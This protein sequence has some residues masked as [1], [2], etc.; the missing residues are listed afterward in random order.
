MNTYYFLILFLRYMNLLKNIAKLF[1]VFV[2]PLF[3]LSSNNLWPQY[4]GKN[5]TQYKVFDWKYIESQHFDVYYDKGS[6]Y[7]AEFAA[8]TLEESLLSIQNTLNYRIT[9]RIAVII[10][11]S[12]NDFQQTN[13]IDVYLSQGIGGVTELYKNRVIVP[14]QGEY[15]QFNHVLHH[16][17]VHAVLN[18]MFYGGNIQTAITTTNFSIPLWMNEGLAEW[19]SLGGMNIETDM[20]M[21][22]LSMNDQIPELETISG[23]AAYRCGQTFYAY[24]ASKYGKNKVTELINKLKIFRNLDMAFENSFGMNIKDFS[25]NWIKDIKKEYWPDI[26]VYQ[27]PK[28]FSKALTD[29]KK[30]NCFYFSSPA[31]SPDGEYMA[32]ISDMS[33]GIFSIYVAPVENRGRGKDTIKPKKI[34]SSAR[35][36]DFEQ[37]NV[38]TPGISWSPD[39][40]F[41][42]VSAKSGGEDAIFIVNVQTKKYEKIKPGFSSI[43]SV[44]WSPDGK[45]IAF[46]GI[47]DLRSDLFYY[48]LDDKTV[49]KITDDVFSDKYPAWSYDSENIFFVSDRGDN[50]E[51]YVTPEKLKIWKVNNEVSDIY[52]VNIYSHEITRITNEPNV[53][54]TS[55]AVSNDNKK[56]LYVSTKNGIGNIYEYIIESNAERPLTNCANGIA[57]LSLTPDNLTLI[58]SVQINGGYD[59]FLLRNPFE[60]QIELTELPKTKFLK[61]CENTYNLVNDVNDIDETEDELQEISYGDFSVDFSNQQFVQP[62][63]TMALQNFEQDPNQD[64]K[65]QDVYYVEK[66][67][68][69][70]FSLDV[71][72]V[73][74]GVSTFYG[75]QGNGAV[76]F[77]DIM[78]NHQIYLQMYLLSDLKNSQFYAAYLYNAKII[79]Y[80]IS[81]YNSSAYVWNYLDELRNNYLYSYR[82]TGVSLG[83]RYPF[84]LFRRLEGTLNFVNA[85]KENTE[86]PSYESVSRFLVVPE[87]QFVLD[88]S[89][90]GIYAPTRGTRLNARA[91]FSPKL[92]ENASDFITLTLDARQYI[93]L[94]PNFMCFALRGAA[95][96]SFGGRSQTFYMGGINNWLNSSFKSGNF[97][98][99]EPEDFAFLQNF[100]MPMRGYPVCELSGDKYF[101]ANIEYRF[102]IFMALM[103][104]GVPVLIQGVMGNLFM[105]V[106]GLWSDN[107]R[108]SSKDV[109]GNRIPE[110]LLMSAGWGLRAILFGLP[111]KFDMAWRNEFSKWSKPYY[112]VSIGLDF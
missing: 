101:L 59:I 72:L 17:L 24:V 18:D 34:I 58:Y 40:K 12:H 35:Q 56:I 54:K 55:I 30:E 99:N 50:L 86:L 33:D 22:D 47:K 112:M 10:Y 9:K 76:M 42:T 67:Y 81:A 104:G 77:S 23:Y 96:A 94:M 78:G 103:T 37:L 111:V 46:V 49:N 53:D 29:H 19:E 83:A 13:V 109:N 71:L 57:Q 65:N 41:I 106:G 92:Y 11:D 1:C 51:K 28:D 3:L 31:I 69:V 88:N 107:F 98:L 108:I 2:M 16:E 62:N 100:L 66:D 73:N 15:S 4:F 63:K 36:N 89:L 48:N 7:L 68:T 27:Y 44:I 74:P 85:A 93:E 52:S 80:S 25:E 45:K 21:R 5:K 90:N 6:K 84:D 20:Y 64:N 82:S 95:G 87:L 91:L 43:T 97:N 8:E 75:V 70:N 26:T 105:D 38:L 79:D 32:Y 61:D 110:N 39:G 14:F 60:K 102:P